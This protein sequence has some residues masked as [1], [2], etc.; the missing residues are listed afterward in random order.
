M[1][2]DMNVVTVL[3]GVSAVT[4]VG[5]VAYSFGSMKRE[6]AAQPDE[7]EQLRRELAELRQLVVTKQAQ[8]QRADQESSAQAEMQELKNELEALKAEQTYAL[9]QAQ[10][11]LNAPPAIPAIDPQTEMRLER[12]AK[13]VANA[14]IMA[15]V[16]EFFPD[17]GFASIKVIN[18]EAV[19]V[20][21][22]LGIRRQT[23]IVGQLEITTVE[24]LEAIGD[25]LPQTF[26][27]GTVDIRPGDELI[28]PP[29]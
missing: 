29:L 7:K 15:Q 12:R 24:G 20:G 19:Q 22:K 10:E 4:L 17:D 1:R 9:Q 16:D 23:G 3:I 11:E 2:R 26:L 28:L 14:M 21:V 25:A 13:V 27:G 18:Y 5:V 6:V 8:D